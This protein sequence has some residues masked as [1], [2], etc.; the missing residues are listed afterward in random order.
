[1]EIKFGNRTI[2]LNPP[3]YFIADIAANHDGDLERMKKRFRTTLTMS[4]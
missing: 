3:T 1:M 4:G 2:G